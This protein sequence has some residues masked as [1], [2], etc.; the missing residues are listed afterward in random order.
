MQGLTARP[1][2]YR[3]ALLSAPTR[4]LQLSTNWRGSCQGVHLQKIA[5]TIEFP[6][7]AQVELLTADTPFCPLT[8]MPD[9]L[10]PNKRHDGATEACL[11]PIFYTTQKQVSNPQTHS[12]LTPQ[13][14]LRLSIR[15]TARQS[16]HVDRQG[17]FQS[18]L[19]YDKVYSVMNLH[20][21][22]LVLSR[23]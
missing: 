10:P 9:T 8:A 21:N 12:S 5:Q 19:Y 11:L 23:V 7:N 6:Q 1:S 17:H 13:E 14:E 18:P 4:V 2:F 16:S 22:L 3:H 15:L 20:V